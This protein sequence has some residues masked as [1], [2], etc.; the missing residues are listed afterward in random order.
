MTKVSEDRLTAL[1]LKVS[2][3]ELKTYAMNHI[4]VIKW[5][6]E[7]QTLK[8]QPYLADLAD[9][10]IKALGLHKKFVEDK[11]ESWIAGIAMLALSFV[12]GQA[13]GWLGS[14]VT[15]RLKSR[16]EGQ[17]Q[18]QLVDSFVNN[19]YQIQGKLN[20]DVLAA[21]W[22]DSLKKT[23][24]AVQDKTVAMLI[25][26]K[27]SSVGYLGLSAAIM[28]ANLNTFKTEIEKAMSI[29]S[30][31]LIA[32]LTGFHTNLNQDETYGYEIL[33]IVDPVLATVTFNTSMQKL[34]DLLP[35]QPNATKPSTPK[36]SAAPPTGAHSERERLGKQLIDRHFDGL[37]QKYAADWFYFGHDPEI[38]A[39]VA[40]TMQIEVEIWKL[41]V[42]GQEFRITN[43][44]DPIIGEDRRAEG[45]DHIRLNE[46]ILRH[47][48]EDL[49]QTHLY[50]LY[51]KLYRKADLFSADIETYEE[52]NVVLKWAQNRPDKTFLRFSRRV[53]EPLN[54][55]AKKYAHAQAQEIA[56]QKPAQSI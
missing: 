23:V 5:E 22:G 29:A 11:D 51:Y 47:L 34:M 33:K 44:Q 40:T 41:W 50:D 27:K 53:I 21:F 48:W 26:D 32:N 49:G 52:L 35:K 43:R 37:R 25:P 38:I 17:L 1:E 36:P 2:A 24:E 4:L 9:L 14:A 10:Q 55:V 46:R 39:K 19:T 7:Q 30:Q 28:G 16:Y 15:K 13:I 3:L 12:G 54:I 20:H 6:Y 56:A 8:W 45:K 42:L 18:S 31:N